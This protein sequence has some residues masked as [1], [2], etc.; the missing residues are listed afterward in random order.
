[1]KSVTRTIHSK[2]WPTLSAALTIGIVGA[3]ISFDASNCA[4]AGEPDAAEISPSRAAANSSAADVAA[5]GKRIFHDTPN[6]AKAYVGNRLT[7]NSCHFLDGTAPHAAPMIGISGLFPMFSRRANRMITL[8]D[9][10]QECFVR[11]ENG[12]PLPENGREMTALV[13]YI[14]S[15]SLNATKRKQFTGRGLVKVPALKG[16]PKKGEELYSS[17][18]AVCHGYAGEGVGA[19]L[20]PVWGEGSFNDGAGMNK[21][22]KM[23]AFVVKNMPPTNPGS[24]T[25]Q[26][27]FDVSSFIHGKPRPK[28]NPKYDKY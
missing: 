20:P 9:R 27:A 7:C 26:Q 6:V 1:V 19:M 15:L 13:A 12:R 4:A 11:S 8:Q 5:L 28:Y 21:V 14:N 25:A 16:N 18:C 22:E 10:I 2:L 3:I 23:A 24:L 17:Q